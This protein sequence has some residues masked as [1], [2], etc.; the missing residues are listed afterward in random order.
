MRAVCRAAA[1]AASSLQQQNVSRECADENLGP[2]GGTCVC[3]KLHV[4]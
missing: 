4:C 1:A 3:G 2:K